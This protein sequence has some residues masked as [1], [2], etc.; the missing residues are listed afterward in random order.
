MKVS[1]AKFYQATIMMGYNLRLIRASNSII[2]CMAMW[3]LGMKILQKWREEKR[4]SRTILKGWQL[5]KMLKTS[6]DLTLHSSLITLSQRKWFKRL[7]VAHKADA[8]QEMVKVSPFQQNL[9]KFNLSITHQT[10]QWPKLQLQWLLLQK[11]NNLF[12]LRTLI[13]KDIQMLMKHTKGP[14]CL[15][16]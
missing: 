11:D 4:L 8:C 7:K 9:V 1:Q 2:I 12:A 6:K 14:R 16:L 10:L 5:L 15:H 13:D 3:H